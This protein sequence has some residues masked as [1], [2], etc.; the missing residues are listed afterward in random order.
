MKTFVSHLY[1]NGT[2]DTSKSIARVL[3]G[4]EFFCRYA[5][6]S[7]RLPR[8]LES[9]ERPALWEREDLGSGRSGF[10]PLRIKIVNREKSV[11]SV[12]EQILDSYG[13]ALR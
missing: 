5:W 9:T 6:L 7:Q 1:Q 4:E 3:L 13:K 8:L 2:E 11:G 10:R 12:K